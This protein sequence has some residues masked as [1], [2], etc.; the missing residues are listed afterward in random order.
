MIENQIMMITIQII[1]IVPKQLKVL[2]VMFILNIIQKMYV[3][4]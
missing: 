1:R 3:K 2:Y 4:I